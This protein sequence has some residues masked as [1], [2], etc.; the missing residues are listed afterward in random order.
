VQT[1]GGSPAPLVPIAKDAFIS[2]D[3][4]ADSPFYATYHFLRGDNGKVKAMKIKPALNILMTRIEPKTNLPL[5]KKKK[6]I[7]L[8]ATILQQYAGKYRYTGGAHFI[9]NITVKGDKMYLTSTV[10]NNPDELFPESKTTFFSKAVDAEI[11]FTKNKD[12]KVT[13]L[14]AHRGVGKF[15]F[16]K[17]K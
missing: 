6:A 13:G 9:I 15:K 3:N 12:G 16:E 1:T 8:P 5:P 2:S 11:T 14:I 17:V 7:Q 10:R 4:G